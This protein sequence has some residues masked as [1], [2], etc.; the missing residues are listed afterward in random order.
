[1]HY[2]IND[3]I[4]KNENK[5]PKRELLNDL[6]VSVF[7]TIVVIGFVKLGWLEFPTEVNV[8]GIFDDAPHK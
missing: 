1:M 7:Y 4:S 6:L 8:E 2:G 5:Y 3:I